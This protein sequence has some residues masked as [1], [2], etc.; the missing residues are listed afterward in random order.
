MDNE[1]GLDVW[2]DKDATDECPLEP[3][4]FKIIRPSTVTAQEMFDNMLQQSLQ[5]L[6]MKQSISRNVLGLW[7]L[8]Q[9]VFQLLS[10]VVA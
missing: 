9:M 1:L 5:S 10:L 4:I 6:G 8:A 7:G 3:A 2:F